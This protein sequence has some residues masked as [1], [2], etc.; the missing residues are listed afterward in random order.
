M[1]VE[2]VPLY[3]MAE[4]RSPVRSPLPKVRAADGP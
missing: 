2:R 4:K 1:V 3:S